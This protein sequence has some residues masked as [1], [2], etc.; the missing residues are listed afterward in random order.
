LS[1]EEE[2][3]RVGRSSSAINFEGKASSLGRS[4]GATD[5][6]GNIGGSLSVLIAGLGKFGA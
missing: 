5:F 3:G 4:S 1:F 2:V 6:K